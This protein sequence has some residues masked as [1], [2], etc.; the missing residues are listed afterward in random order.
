LS[1]GSKPLTSIK[2]MQRHECSNIFLHPM[3]N[4]V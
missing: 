2:Q 4:L 3:I 1:F